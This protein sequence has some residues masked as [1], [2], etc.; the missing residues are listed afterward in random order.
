MWEGESVEQAEP[1]HKLPGG[2]P[3]SFSP[4]YSPLTSG[5]TGEFEVLD[6]LFYPQFKSGVEN[7]RENSFRTERFYNF[8]QATASFMS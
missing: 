3:R 1:L 2:R 8:D 5:E 6:K 4:L 7:R